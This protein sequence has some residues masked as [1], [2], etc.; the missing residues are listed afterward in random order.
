[1][2][3]STFEHKKTT[4]QNRKVVVVTQLI[5]T[6]NQYVRHFPTQVLACSGYEGLKVTTLFSALIKGSPSESNKFQKLI[7]EYHKNK[8]TQY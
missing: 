5:S 3:N 2:R 8:I 7:L 4:F 1:M 6:K